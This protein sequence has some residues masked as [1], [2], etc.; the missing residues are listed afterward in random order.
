MQKLTINKRSWLRVLLGVYFFPLYLVIFSLSVPPA[1]LPLC[2]LM[3][4]LSAFGLVLARR[5]S[6]AWRVIWISAL[7]MSILC[8]VLE[9]VA[10]QRIARQRSKHD[11]SMRLAMPAM[12]CSEM[13]VARWLQSTHPAGRVDKLTSLEYLTRHAG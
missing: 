7:I 3:F 9:V 5:Y 4:V 11:S 13:A 2:G 1:D 8:G 12:S 10:G 6:R